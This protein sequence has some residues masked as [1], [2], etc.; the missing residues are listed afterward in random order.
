MSSDWITEVGER[1]EGGVYQVSNP[2][3]EFHLQAIRLMNPIL[4]VET[5]EEKEGN[6]VVLRSY[7]LSAAQDHSLT[8]QPF[9]LSM[10]SD[11]SIHPPYN[12]LQVLRTESL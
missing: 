5:R 12:F 1:E 8:T 11:S 4:R 7:S 10:L 6:G 9:L 2:E 3:S